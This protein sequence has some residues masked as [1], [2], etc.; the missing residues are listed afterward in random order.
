[1]NAPHPV[2]L[3]IGWGEGGQRP[4]EGFLLCMTGFRL[5]F[6]LKVIIP[7]H[8]FQAQVGAGIAGELQA[9]AFGPFRRAVGPSAVDAVEFSA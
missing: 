8:M 9:T 1:M 4:G 3:P 5:L 2:P 7:E 6:V